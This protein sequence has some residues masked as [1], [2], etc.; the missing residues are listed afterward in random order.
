MKRLFFIFFI[1][2][3]AFCSEQEK[4]QEVEQEQ[5]PITINYLALGDSY[6]IGQ[7]VSPE[8]RWPN[9]L[10]VRLE[11]NDFEVEHSKIIAQ[12]GWTTGNLI[13]ALEAEAL[14]EY[15]L[16]SL[17]IGVNNQ[18]QNQDF[19]IFTEE[20]DE[21]LERAVQIAGNKDSVFVVSIPDY[22]VTPF[23]SSNA[24][25]IGEALDRYNQFISDRC[26]ARGISFINI[27]EI[28]RQLG[29]SP[30]AL[31]PDNLH[32]SGEQY[33]AWVDAILPKTIEIL[34]E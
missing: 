28:S 20:F 27:T 2:P 29:D 16:V 30:G 32:P 34:N 13:T 1:I 17:Q 5:L 7:G 4:Q 15:N 33:R 26:L 24:Q 11:G 18:F 19:G 21:L 12:T 6:T 9:Q 23:G 8:Q 3:M 14:T 10:I 31:A 22:G 25:Q